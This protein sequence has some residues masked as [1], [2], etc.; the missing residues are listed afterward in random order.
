[1]NVHVVKTKC[2]GDCQGQGSGET[3]KM[4]FKATDLQLEDE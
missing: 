2:N 1:M 4:W 3:G